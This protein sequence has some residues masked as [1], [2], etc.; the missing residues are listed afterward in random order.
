MATI[1]VTG[2]EPFGDDDANPSADAV[3]E[4]ATRW[5][6][7]DELVTEVLPVAFDRSARRI[8]ELVAQHQPTIVLA[9]G[10]GGGRA[11]IGIERVAI[12]LRDARIPD[13]DGDQPVDV[14]SIAGG[15]PAYFATLPVKAITAA[16]RDAG[17]EVEISYSAGTF[18]CNHVMFEALDAAADG[19]R[20]GF[21]H[22]PWA[23]GQ[24]PAGATTM[25]LQDMVRAM[26]IAIEVSLARSDDLVT[27][28]GTLD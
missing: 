26:E 27:P 13:N 19:T 1:V 9:T 3:R 23:T 28:G 8:R 25:P 20:A 4:L 5:R 2:F 14:P 6:G 24:G 18:V 17:I 16:I 12:N 7:A 22:V 15:P 11:A 10:L 21:L